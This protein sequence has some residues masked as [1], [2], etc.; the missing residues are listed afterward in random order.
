VASASTT[1]TTLALVVQPDPA[2][3]VDNFLTA[4]GNPNSNWGTNARLWVGA[5]DDNA[6][7]TVVRFGLGAIAP[8]RV[9]TSCVLSVWADI[10]ET[11][12]VGAVLRLS[13][14]A[15]T[16]TG[17]TW[18]RYDGTSAWATPGGDVDGAG[19][20]VFVPPAVPGAYAF[21]DLRALCQDAI[22][23]RGGR[24]DLLIRQGVETLGSPHRQ[25]G[26]FSSDYALD[27]TRR[28]RLVVRN[29]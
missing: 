1:T 26:F 27:P 16:E 19:L 29:R 4:P 9:V 14:P 20:V 5:D 25:W 28:P 24:L 2:T 15:W 3:G 12:D 23:S 11:P 10:V 7:R 18:N 17:S 21:P 22:T 8:T 13:Q 6:Q